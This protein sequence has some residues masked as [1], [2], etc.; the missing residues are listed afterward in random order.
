MVMRPQPLH[1]ESLSLKTPHT[2]PS[3]P[4]IALQNKIESRLEKSLGSTLNIQ[5]KQEM[6]VFQVSMLE[7]MKSLRDETLSFKKASYSAQA[8]PKPGPSN[9]PDP[10]PTWTYTSR[11]SDYLDVQ[12]METDFYGP[13]LP[14]K[15]SQNVQSELASK[16]SDV[17]SDHSKHHSEFKHPKKVCPKPK[18][19]S[20]KRKHKA[21]AKY[22]SQSSSSEEDESSAPS[23]KPTKPQ[24]EAPQEPEH[25]VSTDPVFYREVDMSD[26]PSQYAEE[27]ETFRQIL[28]LTDPRE[29][30]PRSST[31]VLGLDDEKGQQ[32]LRPRGPSAMLPL[33]SILKDAFEKYEQD[34]LASNLPEGKYIKPRLQQPS[35]I[36]WDN[37]VLK[38]SF[39]NL[40]QILPKSVSLQ[41]PLGPLWA[42]FLYK[43]LRNLNIKLPSIS[44]LPPLG[45]PPPVT[46]LWRSA[47]T[48]PRLPSKVSKTILKGCR[49]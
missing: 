24:H 37:L 38:I 32:E 44:H 34:F 15:S 36:T 40:I 2:V 19:H 31:T 8:G 18:K 41:S 49:P 46:L 13:P 12:P 26:L 39:K 21:R 3:T 1:F 30:L 29:T 9:H 23:K 16:Q 25:Q 22:Y 35:T 7:A 11:T 6:G 43:F 17:A 27:M 48:V 5:L 45:L 10:I 20:D 28:D 33:N 42:R 47:Y 4:G 14:P